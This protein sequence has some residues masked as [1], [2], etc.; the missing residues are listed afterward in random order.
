MAGSLHDLSLPRY[1][2]ARTC[3]VKSRIS[4]G[5]TPSILTTG[6]TPP[7]TIGN[8]MCH[9]SFSNS[10]GARGMSLAPKS[11]VA[12]LSRPTPMLSPPVGSSHCFRFSPCRRRSISPSPAKR[13]LS[14]RPWSLQRRLASATS[15]A[16]KMIVDPRCF[17]MRS[18]LS[19]RA[20]PPC[21]TC[22][23]KPAGSCKTS[24]RGRPI[25]TSTLS[26]EKSN[27]MTP[28][29]SSALRACVAATR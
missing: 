17:V 26:C 23:K 27:T 20:A 3:P 11:T 13:R 7:I 8:C 18:T 1:M 21:G 14:P 19:G 5:L 4:P 10:F 9:P 6:T 28:Q 22:N 16:V 15:M 25:V 24:A 29:R 12:F 2:S